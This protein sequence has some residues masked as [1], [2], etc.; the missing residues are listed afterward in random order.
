MMPEEALSVSSVD[1]QSPLKFANCLGGCGSSVPYRTNSK[2]YCS[3]CR[4]K[5]KRESARKAAETQRRKK[6]IQKVK[7]LSFSC[8]ECGCEAVA[9]SGNSQ[10]YCRQCA[11]SVALK[12]ARERSFGIDPLG[13]RRRF[14]DKTV[15]CIDCSSEFIADRRRK[16]CEECTDKS[17]RKPH[18]GKTLC[19][20]CGDEFSSETRKRIYCDSCAE[21]RRAESFRKFARKKFEQMRGD[22]AFDLNTLM[23]SRIRHSLVPGSKGGASWSDIVGYT[24]DELKRHLERQFTRGMTWQ[25]RGVG[26]WHIDHILPI[27]SFNYDSP[28]H[29]DFKACWSLTNLR[30]L[31]GRENISKSDKILYII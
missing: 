22:A 1:V 18:C 21:G 15:I 11:P 3:E 31:W 9:T 13:N 2:V 5:R 26:G 25:N 7:G 30:P 27:A 20:Q 28:N 10:K 6:G 24:V 14:R 8:V 29:P 4:S 12:L 23:R 19:K 17:K 16:R